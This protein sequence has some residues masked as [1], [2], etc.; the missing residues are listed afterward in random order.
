MGVQ[1]R[2]AEPAAA[3]PGDVTSCRVS[4]RNTAGFADRFRV[5]VVGEAS[6]WASVNPTLLDVD[7]GDEG[8]ADI[9]VV[10]PRTWRLTAGA[11]SFDVRVRSLKDPSLSATAQG[12]L[13]IAAF[14]EVGARLEPATSHTTRAAP[15]IVTL[16]NRGNVSVRATI[17]VARVAS[18]VVVQG[19]DPHTLTAAPGRS[20]ASY[21]VVR[22]RRRSLSGSGR[23][24]RFDV[25]VQPAGSPALSLPGTL[26]QTPTARWLRAATATAVVVLL[27]IALVALA[28]AQS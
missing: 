13:R 19:V 4:V 14:S 23:A 21:L 27:A 17:G 6:T 11:V 24:Y 5:E 25:V 12:V 8:V 2:L 3:V 1:A 15:Y 20:A 18:G 7:A 9:A 28:L 16:E 22:C 26:V 10:V